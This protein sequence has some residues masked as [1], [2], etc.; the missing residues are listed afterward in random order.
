M[1]SRH[2]WR[3]S[4]ITDVEAEDAAAEILRSV[5]DQP[6]ASYT[7]LETRTSESCVYFDHAPESWTLL[8]RQLLH[9]LLGLESCGLR[10]G[11]V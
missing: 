8:R 11:S 10:A 5:C 7:D 4:V 3:V 6:L 2:V 1:K 9:R